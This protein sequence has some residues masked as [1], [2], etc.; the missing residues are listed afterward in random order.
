MNFPVLFGALFL[1]FLIL[2]PFIVVRPMLMLDK[3]GLSKNSTYGFFVLVALISFIMGFMAS[4][5]N[6]KTQV[7]GVQVSTESPEP[8]VR[9]SQVPSVRPLP[10]VIP[11]P[12]ANAS[13]SPSAIPATASA[14]PSPK[15]TGDKDCKDFKTQSEAQEYFQSKGGSRTNNVDNLDY[16]HDG[17]ACPHLP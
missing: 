6:Q 15:L 17:T 7:A 4:P 14:R 5:K 11:S 16:D 13:A 9:P 3:I 10:S 1:I 8:Q 12:S 2:I